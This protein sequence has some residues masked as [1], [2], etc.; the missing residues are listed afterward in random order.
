MFFQKKRFVSHSGTLNSPAEDEGSAFHW[1]NFEPTNFSPTTPDELNIAIPETLLRSPTHRLAEYAAGRLCAKNA[2]KEL[3]Y[4]GVPGFGSKR[5]P[6]WPS[7]FW[8]SITHTG[9]IALAM[10]SKKGSVGIDIET[11]VTPT[12]IQDVIG[13]ILTE[14]ER[15]RFGDNLSCELFTLIFSFKESFYKAAYPYVNRFIDFKAVD[16]IEVDWNNGKLMYRLNEHLCGGLEQ[17]KV[18][19]ASFNTPFPNKVLTYVLLSPSH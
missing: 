19:M 13:S 8:G 16:L 6:L 7:S 15:A 17:G 1:V 11:I 18:G 14:S 3:G 2:L 5:E 10:A 4:N 12:L 9:N